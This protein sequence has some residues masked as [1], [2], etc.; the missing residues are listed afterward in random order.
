MLDPAPAMPQHPSDSLDLVLPS[1]RATLELAR[2][3]AVALAPGDMV[4]L[5]GDL[6]TGKTTFARALIRRLAG[7][8]AL[9]VPSPT[10]TLMQIYDLPRHQVIHADLYR[11]NAPEELV[12]LGFADLAA[13]AVAVVEWPDRA[14]AAL[15]VDR[16]DLEFSLAPDLTPNERRVRLTVHGALAGRLERMTLMRRFLQEAE[17]GAAERSLI[18]GDASTR[19]YERLSVGARRA[20]LMNAPRRPDGP[21]VRDGLPYSRL[22]HLAEDVKPFVAMARGLRERGFSAPAIYAA[23]IDAGLLIV[24]DLGV[25]PVATADPPAAIEERYAVAVDLLVALHQ[26]TLPEVLPVAPRIDHRLARYDADALL[27][28][29]ELLVDW[30][31]PYRGKAADESARAEFAALWRPLLARA[32]AAPATWVLRDYHSPNLLWLGERSGIARVGLLDFQDAVLGSAAYDVVS[33]LQDARVDVSES[34]ETRLVSRYVKARR[35]HDRTFDFSAFFEIYAVLGAQRASKVLGIFA[36]LAKRDGKSQYLR[37]HPRV[38]RNLRRSLA[39]PALRSLKAWYDERAPA[40]A[41]GPV[42]AT[43]EGAT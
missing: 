15:P 13:D 28:E 23:D 31:L 1:E 33:L 22:V 37:H 19:I 32:A 35:A 8:E 25:E 18:Q 20:V 40:P 3:I 11:V 24:E 42:E 16:L 41:S 5:S 6:G 29:A 10:F 21:P 7:D 39:H 34:I 30:Y 2:E 36:R 38:W 43:M 14:A 4:A 17:F 9:E 27:I 12:E 26:L